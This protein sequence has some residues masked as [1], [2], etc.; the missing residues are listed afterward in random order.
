MP[1]PPSPS[2]KHDLGHNRPG[3]A[4]IVTA[5]LNQKVLRA[6]CFAGKLTCSEARVAFVLGRL[7]QE[8]DGLPE[9]DSGQQP[10]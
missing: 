4:I 8:D 10:G 6:L 7:R 9:H 1:A 5:N 2:A 3:M